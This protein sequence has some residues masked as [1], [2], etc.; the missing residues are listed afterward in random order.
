MAWDEVRYSNGGGPL[1]AAY[2]DAA[3]YSVRVIGTDIEVEV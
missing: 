1:C 3:R 2:E